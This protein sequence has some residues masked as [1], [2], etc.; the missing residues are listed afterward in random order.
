MPQLQCVLPCVYYVPML[1]NTR[2]R[3]AIR[4]ALEEVDRPLSPQEVLKVAQG[5]APSLGMAT[6]YRT[7][8]ELV[9]DGWLVPVELPGEPPRYESASKAHHH[10]FHCRQCRQVYEID[11][12]PQNLKPLTPAGFTLEN[13]HV[14][15]SGLCATCG[16][17]V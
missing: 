12:C 17:T 8:K 10:H 3:Q 4:R 13:H 11:G 7:L 16:H 2:Q 9:A 5:H 6:V 1:R 14:V 15:L